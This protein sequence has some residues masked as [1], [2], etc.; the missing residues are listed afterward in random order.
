MKIT[1]FAERYCSGPNYLWTHLWGEV[2]EL[3]VEVRR[4][5]LRGVVDEWWDVALTFQL[6]LWTYGMDF[7]MVLAVRAIAKAER[8]RQAWIRIFKREGLEFHPRYLRGGSNFKK[9]TKVA[10]ALKLAREGLDGL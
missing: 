5:N 3:L 8:R 1:T 4:A 7:E 6:I 10:A 2:H 9:A